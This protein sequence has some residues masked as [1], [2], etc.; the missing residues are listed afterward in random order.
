MNNEYEQARKLGLKSYREALSRGEYPYLHVLDETLSHVTIVAENQLGLMEI[1]IDRIYGTYTAGRRGAFAPNF[2]PL[3]APRTEFESKWSALYKSHLEEG[4]KEPVIAYEYMNR[5]YIAEGNKRVSILK[6]SGAASV[7]GYVT[8]LIP[9]RNNSLQN[10]VYFEYL[11]FYK[12]CP[13]TQ[14]IFTHP[15]SYEE[16]RTFV[17]K[18]PGEHWTTDERMDLDAAYLR[19]KQVFDTR[20]SEAPKNL[21][22]AD[23]FLTF[24][25]FY[26]YREVLEKI[27]YTLKDDLDRVWDDIVLSAEKEPVELLLDSSDQ[28]KK[29]LFSVIFGSQKPDRPLNIAFIYAKPPAESGWIYGHELGRIALQEAYGDA[30]HTYVRENVRVEDLEDVLEEVIAEGADIIF[31]TTPVFLGGCLKAAARHPEVK[32]LDCAINSSHRYVRTYY[33][34]IYEAKF[35]SGMIAGIMTENDKIGYFTDYPIHSNLA[36][37]NAFA[38]GVEMVNP[39]ARVHVQWDSLSGSDPKAYFEEQDIRIISGRELVLLSD[40]SRE[41]GLY[42]LTEDGHENLAMPLFNWGVLY[43]K[44]VA[45]ILNG[46][47]EDVDKTGSRR[48]LNYWWGMSSD[49]IDIICSKNV[50]ES[51]MRLI[52]FMRE[53]IASDEYSPFYG[54][55]YSQ[56]GVIS[57]DPH[58]ILTPRE[59]MRMKWLNENIIGRIPEI[60]ELT[61]EGQAIMVVQG[62]SLTEKEELE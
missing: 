23:A 49:A 14:L 20:A 7:T 15:G 50:P 26:E 53:R 25:H 42:R 31:A 18:E 3:L 59:I 58:G 8:R 29:N 30:L 28:P 17:G 47:Y 35:L 34:R 43:R 12:D 39:K 24:L 11:D 40:D 2:M 32:I 38:R 45:S 48:A 10:R 56:D 37:L 9:E 27:P 22:S 61:P 55:I 19:F 21:T 6:F 51:V 33:A 60:E 1:P 41:F 44:L 5:Y 36:N 46:T 57:D 62:K 13:T 16:L 4:I 52:D 54:K